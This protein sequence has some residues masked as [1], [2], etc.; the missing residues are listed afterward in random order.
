MN[1]SCDR[2]GTRFRLPDD[3]IPSVGAKTTCPRCGNSLTVR[4]PSPA[5]TEAA[6]SAARYFVRLRDGRPLGSFADRQIRSMIEQGSLDG[7][8][9]VSPDGV[10]WFGLGSVQELQ[11]EGAA[12]PETFDPLAGI[13]EPE[14][15]VG[16]DLL[17]PKVLA[18]PTSASPPPTPAGFDDADLLAPK[19]APLAHAPQA[20]TEIDLS[21]DL[22][23][24]KPAGAAPAGPPSSGH[25]SSG[26]A[27]SAFPPSVPPPSTPPPAVPP[28]PPPRPATPPASARDLELDLDEA[29]P[30]G[31]GALPD[32][33]GPAPASTVDL[34]LELP[35]AS[36]SADGGAGRVELDSVELRPQATP[37]ATPVE[38]VGPGARAVSLDT[39]DLDAPGTG[40]PSG[41]GLARRAAAEEVAPPKRLPVKWLA[42]AALGAVLAGGVALGLVTEYGFFGYYLLTGVPPWERSGAAELSRRGQRELTD[43][44][45]DSYGR[46]VDLFTQALDRTPS[47][48][49]ARAFRA[50][51]LF[52]YAYRHGA[53]PK[54]IEQA[55]ADLA[56]LV[57]ARG[58]ASTERDKARALELLAAGR[59]GEA[60]DILQ[61]LAEREQQD[62]LAQMYYGWALVAGRRPEEALIPL[63]R[64]VALNPASDGAAMALGLALFSAGKAAE[65][66]PEL[67]KVLRRS[68]GNLAASV[69]L[70]EIAWRSGDDD[71]AGQ[72]LEPVLEGGT[73]PQKSRAESVLGWIAKS[74]GNLNEAEKRLARAVELDPKNVLGLTG[75]GT[76]LY[77]G[78]R[79]KEALAKC[80]IA[81][82]IAL[83]DAEAALCVARSLIHL[84]R[85][86]DARLEVQDVAKRWPK[87]AE[88]RFLLG[89]IEE[90]MERWELAEQQYREAIAIDPKFFDA[91]AALS[92]VYLQSGKTADA[93]AT[94]KQAENEMGLTARIHNAVGEAWLHGKDFERATQS[95]RAAIEADPA[96]HEARFNLANTLRDEGRLEEAKEQY[97]ATKALAQNLPGV[98]E[99]LGKLYLEL[100]EEE[101]AL[102][103]FEVALAAEGTTVE[104][105]LAA[106]EVF[107]GAGKPDRARELAD[108]VLE[109]WPDHSDA[110][111]IVGRALC[112]LGKLEEGIAKLKRAIAIRN[113]PAYQ[114]ALGE[115]HERSGRSDLAITYYDEALKLDPSL[116]DV[117]IRRAR[118]QL[119]VGRLSDALD[120]LKT[121]VRKEKRADALVLIGDCYLEMRRISS[122]V[123]AYQEAAK[124]DEGFADAYYKL[125]RAHH[126][127]G[128][129]KK[130]ITQLRK[131]LEVGMEKA[132]W[133]ADAHLLLGYAYKQL[134]QQTEAIEQFKRYLEMSPTDAPD[135][136]EVKR[137]LRYLGVETG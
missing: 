136:E 26:R 81:K 70:G 36:P 68:P 114:A 116:V 65:A 67:E 48:M 30:A 52:A 3:R 101:R 83:E 34:D 131:A 94:L 20:N 31:A 43:D 78:G 106:A 95:F 118:I 45:P 100:G 76:L 75:M 29:E 18:P 27:P 87:N 130:A 53:T 1:I 10:T 50:Q 55:R 37:T 120:D 89:R 25:A 77:E 61:P 99:A 126:D 38:Q 86:L 107:L 112:D 98:A 105:R 11:P 121:A 66:I 44:T 4:P 103:E 19:V 134:R 109:D 72:R 59:S 40:M 33:T 58:Q 93:F 74:A 5:P 24:P 15:A 104:L 35:M 115:A 127:E 71:L 110:L 73:D 9:E 128:K 117:R 85:Q 12:A 111:S 57:D 91:Y 54:E 88:A 14:D 122:A 62:A 123:R 8:E 32:L 46:A 13:D 39:V 84:G 16:A 97:E 41:P 133:T 6:S 92:G 108:S 102:A 28:M 2:C 96:Y 63:K 64:A 113:R 49:E 119:R 7:S 79:P 56:G 90:E 137:E 80:S 132:P 82:G 124:V 60:I 69:T 22:P 51:A 21:L 47:Y 129:A 42:V 135:R 23:A 17:A 125:G